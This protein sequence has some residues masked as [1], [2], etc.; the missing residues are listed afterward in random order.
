MR[1]LLLAC[2]LVLTA[3]ARA[4]AQPP[5]GCAQYHAASGPVAPAA[6]SLTPHALAIRDFILYSHRKITDDLVRQEGVYLDTLLAALS[7]CPDNAVKTGWLRR[8]VADTADISALAER[9]ARSADAA[10]PSPYVAP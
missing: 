10:C 4:A 3:P 7:V 9:V 5:C 8:A 6:A 1:A 2:I